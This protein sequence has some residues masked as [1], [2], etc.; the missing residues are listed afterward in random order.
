MEAIIDLHGCHVNPK[1]TVMTALNQIINEIEEELSILEDNYEDT[2]YEE[3]QAITDSEKEELI[4]TELELS[5]QF[6]G[7]K[8]EL[9]D[10]FTTVELL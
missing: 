6:D 8:D 3:I 4:E 5:S 1:E 7:V 10:F 2:R 9:R